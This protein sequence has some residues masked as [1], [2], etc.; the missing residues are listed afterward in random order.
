[1]G[2][3]RLVAHPDFPPTSVKGVEVQWVETGSA[4]RLRY[5]VTGHEELIVPPFAGRGRAD[6]LWRTTCFELYLQPT[7]EPGY[8]EFNFSPSQRWAAYDFEDYRSGMRG[9]ELGAEPVGELAAGERML[10]QD[11]LLDT[12]ALP[13]RPWSIGLSAILEESGGGLS[14][15]ALA[16]APGKPDFH[17]PAGFTLSSEDA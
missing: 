6:E 2:T 9:R 13:P 7:G 16:H 8:V 14:Y 10:V 5:R 12:A 3:H 1:L 11:V 15:W 4:L 17:H